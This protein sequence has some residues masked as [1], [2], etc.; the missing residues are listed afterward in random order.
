VAEQ[1]AVAGGFPADVLAISSFD[2]RSP[3]AVHESQISGVDFGRRLFRTLKGPL[4]V[5]G[6]MERLMTTTECAP[7]LG[8]SAVQVWRLIK[9]GQLK[10][11]Q[12]GDRYGVKPEDLNQLAEKRSAIK[13]ATQ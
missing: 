10:A 12:C 4:H 6:A 7:V 8:L 2:L 3:T 5:E 9:N 11:T 1:P 13:K